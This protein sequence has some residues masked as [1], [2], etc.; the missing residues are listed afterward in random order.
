M[1]YSHQSDFLSSVVPEFLYLIFLKIITKKKLEYQV[2]SQED[3]IIDCNFDPQIENNISFEKKRVDVLLIKKAKFV[4][5]DV[6][7]PDFFI[8][9]I[10]ALKVFLPRTK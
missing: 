8:P 9:L 7:Y 6:D 10:V 4:F 2:K 1:H 5:N 3:I